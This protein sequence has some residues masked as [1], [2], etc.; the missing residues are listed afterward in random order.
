MKKI[1]TY[2]EDELILPWQIIPIWTEEKDIESDFKNLMKNYNVNFIIFIDNYEIQ[3]E[4]R[5]FI[6]EM[7]NDHMYFKFLKSKNLNF[8]VFE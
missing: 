2:R 3:N 8:S 1:M 7:E 5:N 6:R 4:S